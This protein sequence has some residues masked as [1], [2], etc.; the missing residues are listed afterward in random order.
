MGYKNWWE[1]WDWVTK[2]GGSVGI[3]ITDYKSGWSVG[4]QIGWLKPNAVTKLNPNAVTNF[5]N[6]NI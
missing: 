5:A 1:R 3:Q 4:I 6:A 2:I